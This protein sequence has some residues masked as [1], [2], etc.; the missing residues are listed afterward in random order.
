MSSFSDNAH[1]VFISKVGEHTLL[2][3]DSNKTKNE[4][5]LI[6]RKGTDQ[7]KIIT[8]G[9]HPIHVMIPVHNPNHDPDLDII[10]RAATATQL[11]NPF[12]MANENAES[13][14]AARLGSGPVT[15]T[16]DNVD[17]PRRE[18]TH[19][20]CYSLGKT[21]MLAEGQEALMYNV[22]F[23]FI[24]SH[25]P[26]DG[27]VP[28]RVSFSLIFGNPCNKPYEKPGTEDGARSGRVKEDPEVIVTPGGPD[29]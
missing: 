19:Y 3:G 23:S 7:H 6:L 9:F 17:D 5:K 26:A 21:I 4:N 28:Q 2:R 16:L 1:I 25:A 8:H 11:K 12:L 24:P 29:E 15:I 27:T 22:D 20:L 18:G 13:F 10:V 14:K